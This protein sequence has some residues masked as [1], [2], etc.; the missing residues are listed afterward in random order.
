M[1]RITALFTVWLVCG[2]CAAAKKRHPAAAPV[3]RVFV[4]TA[5]SQE[6]RAASGEHS[7]VGTVAADPKVLPL[8]SLILVSRAG[9][10]SGRYKV[11]DTGP[12]VKGRRIDIYMASDREA[13]RFGRRRVGV[14]V[15]R[16]GN[17]PEQADGSP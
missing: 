11:I 4:A 8:G 16:H 1:Q 15:L 6:G 3:T 5:H 17:G 2:G 12:G 13:R 9:K 7:R 14:R 10:Y